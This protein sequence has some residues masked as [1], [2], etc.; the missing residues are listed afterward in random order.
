MRNPQ[1][2][3][4]LLLLPLIHTTHA[5]FIIEPCSSSDSCTSLLSYLLPWDSKLSEIA[6]RFQLNVTDLMAANSINLTVSYPGNQ[7][8]A[9]KTQVKI[10]IQC[11]CVDGIRRSVST[12]YTVRP[13]DSLESISEG[14][15]GLVSVDQIRIGNDMNEKKNNQLR[16][17]ESILIPLP[18]TCFGN[19]DNGISTVFMSYVVQREES[20]SSIGMEFGTTVND[21][22]SVN[23]LG[24]PVVDP[25]DVL[26]IP[27]PGNY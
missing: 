1:Q 13:A 26:A 10:P 20:L 12:T 5:K 11:Y 16:I 23:G 7:I 27:I 21:L 25:G 8:L 4:L 19:S 24:Q 22:V 2:L 17:G 18:C 15:G 3:L 14:F 9:A 6:F